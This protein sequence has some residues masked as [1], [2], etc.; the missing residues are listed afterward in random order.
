MFQA[1]RRRARDMAGIAA[2]CRAAEAV[3]R[4]EGLAEPDAEHFLL[5]SLD[6]PDG[7]AARAWAA[8][9]QSRETLHAAIAG[10]YAEAL[11]SIGVDADAT[12]DVDPLPEDVP[13]GLFNASGSAQALLQAMAANKTSGGPFRAVEVFTA[14]ATLR[15][16]VVP[17]ALRRLGIAP[18]QLAA[19]G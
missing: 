16:G 7:S 9:G 1:L 4:T 17:R 10:Q 14:A 6:M 18:E 2:L 8:L 19:L 11:A 12:G 3:A 13:A 5:A 15:H